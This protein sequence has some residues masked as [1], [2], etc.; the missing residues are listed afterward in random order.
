LADFSVQLEMTTGGLKLCGYTG[1]INDAKG[2]FQ[3]NRAEPHHHKRIPAN[4]V[5][6][7]HEPPDIS[8]R[9]LQLYA[10]IRELFETELCGA[11]FIGPVGIDACVYRDAAGATR[12]KPIVE[13][14]PR[15]TMGR[16]T[17]ELMKQACPGSHGLF[18]LI[19]RTALRTEGFDDFSAFAHSLNE[20]LPIR[21]EG[22]PFPRIREGVLCLNDPVRAQTCLA[23]FRVSREAPNFDFT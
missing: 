4:V 3:A 1:L 2:Q 18:R 21:L 19:N 16:L 11:D 8:S 20:Q 6:L 14:N 5:A 10:D 17:V 15:Y 23:M 12:L 7:F 9:L 22:E 13:I